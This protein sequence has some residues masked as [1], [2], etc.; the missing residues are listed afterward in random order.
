[1]NNDTPLRTLFDTVPTDIRTGILNILSNS[2]N[3]TLTIPTTVLKEDDKI[4]I[5]AEMPGFDKDSISVDFF[6]NKVNI[7]GTKNQPSV[8]GTILSSRIKYGSFSKCLVLPIS[9]TDRRNVNINYTD[10]VLTI[11]INTRAE[12]GNRFIV[13]LGSE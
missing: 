9:I 13:S 4:T 10:G 1:M 12:E 11:D 3:Q 8:E 2:P 6:N 7:A 5:Y